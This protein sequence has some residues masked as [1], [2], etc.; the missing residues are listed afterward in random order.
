MNI[1]P[2]TMSQQEN[3]GQFSIF[4]HLQIMLKF[5]TNNNFRNMNYVRINYECSLLNS[6]SDLMNRDLMCNAV[7][8]RET[9]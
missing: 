8:A 9:V 4:C 3:C 6:N 7:I 1:I 2:I 5:S